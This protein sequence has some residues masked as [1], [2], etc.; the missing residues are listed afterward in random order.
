[1]KENKDDKS[2]ELKSLRRQAEKR[3]RHKSRDVSGISREDVQKLIHEL[4]VHQIEL[5]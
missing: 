5:D 4:E 1:M 3:L 2:Q